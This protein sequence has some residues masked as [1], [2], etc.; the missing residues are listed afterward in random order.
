[1]ALAEKKYRI[2]AT[3]KTGKYQV[4]E[5]ASLENLKKKAAELEKKG[6]YGYIEH[7]VNHRVMFNFGKSEVS[8]ASSAS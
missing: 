1:M 8:H 3:L 7:T 2:R 5:G 4:N 6:A